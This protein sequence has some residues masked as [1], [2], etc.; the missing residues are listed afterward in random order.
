[1]EKTSK[2]AKQREEVLVSMLLALARAHQ[3]PRRLHIRTQ[4]MDERDLAYEA[5]LLSPMEMETTIYASQKR[6][7]V[8]GLL[9]ELEKHGWVKTQAVPP[10]G[11]HHV[12]LT[13]HG[14]E[15]VARIQRSRLGELWKWLT[16]RLL[17]LFGAAERKA[18]RPSQGS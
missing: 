9:R 18:R 7:R 15:L 14:E 1:M 12:F 10:L 16:S 11:A 17:K 13:P 8:L 5:D 6:G 4:G 3:D 2:E